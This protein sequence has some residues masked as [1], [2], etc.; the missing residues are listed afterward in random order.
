VSKGI[1]QSWNDLLDLFDSKKFSPGVVWLAR[2]GTKK[3]CPELTVAKVFI[4]GTIPMSFGYGL[5]PCGLE[6]I[7]TLPVHLGFRT[8][9]LEYSE[10]ERFPHPYT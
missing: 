5:E 9:S 4:P 1:P 2:G 10:L 6:R 3:D 7:Y 8:C